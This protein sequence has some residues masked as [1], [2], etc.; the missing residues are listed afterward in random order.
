MQRRLL[1][2]VASLALAGCA[3]NAFAASPQEDLVAAWLKGTA[4]GLKLEIGASRFEPARQAV[5]L[6]N[7]VIGEPGDIVYVTYPDLTFEDPRTTPEGHFAAHAVR[8][9]SASGSYTF[10]FARL[11][12]ELA[13]KIAEDG[14]GQ[15]GAGQDGAGTGSDGGETAESQTDVPTAIS[16]NFTSDTILVERL[17]A[18]MTMPAFTDNESYLDRALKLIDLSAQVRVD[19]LE[20]NNFSTSTAGMPDGDQ[21]TTYGLYYFA[22]LHD[23]RLERFGFNDMQQT[24]PI[25]GTMQTVTIGNN[26]NIGF[27]L[28]AAMEALDPR[29]YK[30]G[31]GDGRWR[32]VG[33]QSGYNDIKLTLP[34]AEVTIGNI[35]S[36]GIRLRQTDKPVIDLFAGILA[37]P[38][39]IEDD[40]VTF[41]TE[42]MPNVL[43]LYGVDFTQMADLAITSTPSEGQDAASEPVTFKMAQF[44]LNNIDSDRIGALTLRDLEFQAGSEGSGTLKMLTAQNIRWGSL[45]SW[46]NLGIA[47]ESGTEPSPRQVIE[48]MLEGMPT[49]DFFELSSL[50]I[51]TPMGAVSL[52]AYANTQGDYYRNLA[53]HYET[54]FTRLRVPVALIP[55]PEANRRLTAMGYEEIDVSG[56]FSVQ[57]DEVKGDIHLTDA[58]IRVADIGQLSADFHIGNLPLSALMVDDP[59]LLEDRVKDITFNSATVT[60][61]NHSIVERTFEMFAKEQNQKPEDFRKNFGNAMPLMLGFLEDKAIQQTFAKELSAFFND[62]QA[63]TLSIRPQAPVPAGVLE[64]LEQAPPSEIFKLLGLKVTTNN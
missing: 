63:I 28:K 57:Y 53:R 52:D 24:L 35:E 3:S 17:V 29:Q 12:P 42:I 18:P 6:E 5:V 14:A 40:P 59:L 61:G 23:G 26:Y 45:M 54:T 21:T 19:W 44:D 15:D 11:F 48:V 10:D 2:S 51:E 7:V 55:D 4:F 64:T 27:D 56:A 49:I 43:G 47:T 20:Y 8:A 30:D 31:K 46:I 39:A 22:G 34:G 32:V 33:E 37:N 38:D 36:N 16:V 58:T 13:D 41:L 1:L 60:F 9:G 50:N 62:P 25:E